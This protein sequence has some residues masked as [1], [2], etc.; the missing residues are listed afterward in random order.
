MRSDTFH[1]A[2]HA[3][4]TPPTTIPHQS[5]FEVG[6]LGE[7][8]A[9]A[10]AAR[11]TV[12]VLVEGARSAARW[13]V[14]RPQRLLRG[15]RRGC[16]KTSSAEKVEAE[17]RARSVI[18]RIRELLKLNKKVSPEVVGV[19]QQIED[20][21]NSPTPSPASR[22]QDSDKSRSW[23]PCRSPSGSR[24]CRLMESEISVLQVGS[25]SARAS[26]PDGEDAT[27]EYY[28][29]EQRRR[30]RRS[31]GDE[32]GKDELASSKTRSRRQALQ[33]SPREG[34]THELKKLRQM[35]PMSA[36]AKVVRNYH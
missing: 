1:P 11:G 4:K 27:R 9:A 28:L 32:E 6:T 26:R 36:E 31:W 21:A 19:V 29:N 22:G 18:N 5:I 15:H 12:K 14:H 7:R 13:S 24:R 34:H 3:E 8:A 17:A 25:A 2:R 35:S 16:S 10:Q 33:G 30:S 23:R 20:Y